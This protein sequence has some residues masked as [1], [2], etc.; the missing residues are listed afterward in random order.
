R[1]AYAQFFRSPCLMANVALRN[2]RFLYKM[3]ISGCR[4][5]EGFGNYFDVRK[6]ALVGLDNQTIGPDSPTVLSVKVLYS[7][8]GLSTE[9]Q[10]HHGRGELLSTS[11]PATTD[12]IWALLKDDLLDPVDQL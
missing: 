8:P 3:G 1:R 10:G 4:W 6:Q 5:F 7:Y 9:D 2:W 12:S 11:P